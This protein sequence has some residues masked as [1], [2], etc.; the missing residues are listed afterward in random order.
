MN[1]KKPL[2]ISPELGKDEDSVQVGVIWNDCP[3]KRSSIFRFS[4]SR[5][6]YLDWYSVHQPIFCCSSHS[7]DICPHPV[8]HILLPMSHWSSSVCLAFHFSFSNLVFISPVFGVF[9]YVRN[10]FF[11]ELILL[12]LICANFCGGNRQVMPRDL[13]LLRDGVTSRCS[14]GMMSLSPMFS[15]QLE[16][17]GQPLLYLHLLYPLQTMLKKLDALDLDIENFGNT[18]TE[19]SSL[20][21]GLV[22]RGHFDSKNIQRQQVNTWERLINGISFMRMWDM[23]RSTL[24]RIS[25][26]T[27]IICFC[28][29]MLDIYSYCWACES[30]TA[31]L[32]IKWARVRIALCYRFE[33][34]AFLFSPLTPLFTQLYKWV[35]GHRQWWKCEWFSIRA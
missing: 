16:M 23:Q 25:I 5:H 7:P 13:S 20:C 2:L 1:E 27:F 6:Y 26:G 9:L 22:Q 15:A 8:L 30:L 10:N 21:K 17:Q 4:V 12:R 18:I 19:L 35:P 24:I 28:K 3:H 11:N 31:G 32:A 14:L 34:W 33:D 29:Q